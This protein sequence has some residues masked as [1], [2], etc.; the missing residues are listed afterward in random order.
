MSS[1]GKKS[2]P[3]ILDARFFNARRMELL[4]S[5]GYFRVPLKEVAKN[6]PN[7]KILKWFADRMKGDGRGDVGSPTKDLATKSSSSPRKAAF[8]YVFGKCSPKATYRG[9]VVKYLSDT[10]RG[11]GAVGSPGPEKEFIEAAFDK[12][13]SYFQF[14]YCI[15]NYDDKDKDDRVA[16]AACIFH[17]GKDKLVFVSYI[18]RTMRAYSKETFRLGNK[19]KEGTPFNFEGINI[20]S[21]FFHVCQIYGAIHGK[22]PP[23][24]ICPLWLQVSRREPSRLSHKRVG[25]KPSRISDL[26]KVFQPDGEHHGCI[27]LVLNGTEQSFQDRLLMMCVNGRYHEKDDLVLDSFLTLFPF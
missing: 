25:F 24:A 10:F 22:L 18:A 20:A 9:E 19:K 27:P 16:I 5:Q 7:H 14:V 23:G 6:C 8:Q 4:E 2:T 1:P 12:G 13:N 21:V 11:E 3:P 15:T 17:L 26:P